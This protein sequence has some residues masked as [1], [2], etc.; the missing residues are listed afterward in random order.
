MKEHKVRKITHFEQYFMISVGIAIM[1]GG[2][3][4]FLIPADLFAG[5]VTGIGLIVNEISTKISISFVVFALNILLLL[6]ALVT[7]GLKTVLR[8]IYGSLLF[9]LTLFLYETFIPLFD[10]ENDFLIA[11]IFGGSLVGLGFGL[12]LKYGGTSG[13]TD[14]PVKLFNKLFNLPISLSIYLI[15][16]VIVLIGTIVFY[17]EHGILTG[18]Y[19]IIAIYI[20]GKI[21]DSVIVGGDSKKAMQ[22]ITDKPNE[23]KKAIYSSVNRGVTEIDITGGYTNTNRTML[24]TVITRREYYTIRNIIARIDEG[25]FVY[26]TSATEIH[27]DFKERESA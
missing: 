27:G 17:Q 12:V 5:G 23:I 14:I 9:P 21:A 4:F 26:V 13:G 7:L 2:F 6:L 3:Y 22:I 15:D 8:S 16:G 20:S 1:A 18:L 24:V 10:I 11:T 25:A 19:A